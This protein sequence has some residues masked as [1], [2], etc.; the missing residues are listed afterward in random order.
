MYKLQTKEVVLGGQ[1]LT[2]SEA[3]NLA[4]TKRY[5]LISEAEKKWENVDIEGIEARATHYLETLL[6]PTLL[7]C[8]TGNVPTLEDFLNSIPPSESDIWVDTA[9][10][11]NPRWFPNSRAQTPEEKVAEL[12]KNVERQTSSSPD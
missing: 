5:M 1:T 6:Y 12:E 7:A 8:T 3:S 4:E 9:R 11:L 10:E 2:V